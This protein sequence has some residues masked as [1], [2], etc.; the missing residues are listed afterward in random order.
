MHSYLKGHDCNSDIYFLAYKTCLRVSN[1]MLSSVFFLLFLV[2]WDWVSWYYGHYWPVVPAP[3]DRWW[4]LWRNWWNEVWQGKLK[5]SEKTCPNATL[6]TTNPTWLDPGLNPDSHGGKPAT[7]RLSYGAA[8][9]SVL[10]HLPS[11]PMV[12]MSLCSWILVAVR[13]IHCSYFA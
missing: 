2:G 7:N 3:D 10:V 11:V 8:L 6:S 4:R 1:V 13:N 5:D 12:A 9:S